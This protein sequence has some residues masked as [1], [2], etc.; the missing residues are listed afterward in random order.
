VSGGSALWPASYRCFGEATTTLAVTLGVH[1]WAM[2]CVSAETDAA[3]VMRQA[4]MAWVFWRI[5]NTLSGKRTLR[6]NKGCVDYPKYANP[7]LQNKRASLNE[8]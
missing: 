6:Q 3:A 2:T 7:L 8:P 5:M 4:I 1:R